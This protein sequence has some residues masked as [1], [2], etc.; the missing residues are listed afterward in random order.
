MRTTF[1]LLALVALALAACGGGSGEN[2]G[3]DTSTQEDSGQDAGSE[4]DET[5][6]PGET[7]SDT[8]EGETLVLEFVNGPSVTVTT[9]TAPDVQLRAYYV[10]SYAFGAGVTVTFSLA[11][12]GD[13]S[14]GATTA[15]IDENGMGDVSFAA[16][17]TVGAAYTLTAKAAGAAD[18]TLALQVVGLLTGSVIVTPT[19]HFTPEGGETLTLWF[20]PST[21]YVCGQT[22]PTD[23]PAD[24][25]KEVQVTDL[26]SPLTVDGL[27]EAPRWSVVALVTKANGNPLANGCVAGFVIETEAAPTPVTL[28]LALLDLNATATY[29][30]TATTSFAAWIDPGLAEI[31]AHLQAHFTAADLQQK[32]HDQ[33][34]AALDAKVHTEHGGYKA[35]PVECPAEPSGTCDDQQWCLD[36]IHAELDANLAQHLA[37]L[38]GPWDQLT[39]FYDVATA[40][41]SNAVLKGQIEVKAHVFAPPAH[42]ELAVRP[43][44]LALPDCGAATCEWTAEQLKAVLYGQDW[45]EPAKTTGTITEYDRVD[46]DAFPLALDAN[47]LALLVLTDVLGPAAFGTPDLYDW[48]DARFGCDSLAPMFSGAFRTCIWSGTADLQALCDDLVHDYNVPLQ[49]WL[50]PL[51]TQNEAQVTQTLTGTDPDGDLELD[52]AAGTISWT[53]PGGGAPLE[54]TLTWTR[55]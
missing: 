40:L 10:P 41:A 13:A 24:T 47:R 22:G 27:P 5:D 17:T 43:T 52:A 16:G 8:P 29:A 49:Q 44:S 36:L 11:G 42:Y 20:V 2:T 33:M 54:G 39:D 7:A 28:D 12:E 25:Y 18:V 14:L 34:F 21:T 55:P 3:N 50:N 23:K 46:V 31:P 48:F 38:P 15:V 32:L 51:A 37:N 53:R 19:L 45:G 9:G 1:T 26:A 4:T 30:F 6:V 35:D